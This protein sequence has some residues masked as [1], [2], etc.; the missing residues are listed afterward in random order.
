[1]VLAKLAQCEGDGQVCH[2]NVQFRVDAL[3]VRVVV[4]RDI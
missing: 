4:K 1:M 2:A 3:V